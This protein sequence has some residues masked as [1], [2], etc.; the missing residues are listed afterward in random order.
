[1]I[2][3]AAVLAV[4]ALASCTPV[5]HAAVFYA[6]DPAALRRIEQQARERC[7]AT[8]PD[9]RLPPYAFTTDGCSSWPDGDWS[10]CCV[11]HDAMY[12]CGGSAEA[13]AAADAELRRCVARHGHPVIGEVMHA[14]VRLGGHPWVPFPWRWGYGWDWPYRHDPA[15]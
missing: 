11:E 14:G 12:W 5:R 1:M 8:R 6:M 3:L 13:R 2:A 9:G 7:A 15:P 10:T 4:G